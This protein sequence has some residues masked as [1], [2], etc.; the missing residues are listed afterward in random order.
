MVQIAR[1]N[2]ITKLLL[3]IEICVLIPLTS[4][5]SLLSAGAGAMLAG[6]EGGAWGWG[7]MLA[8]IYGLS[9]GGLLAI[10]APIYLHLKNKLTYLSL[11]VSTVLVTVFIF[12]SSL[13]FHWVLRFFL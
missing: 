12:I 9:A 7:F 10:A 3:A 5:M 2:N 1:M 11:L 4:Y 6:H 8:A 13:V